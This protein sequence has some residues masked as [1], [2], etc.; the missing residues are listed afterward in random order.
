MSVA[1][2]VEASSDV[3][4]LTVLL[5]QAFLIELRM[6]LILAKVHRFHHIVDISRTL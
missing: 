4:Q 6:N 1:K 3:H 5:A 2:F